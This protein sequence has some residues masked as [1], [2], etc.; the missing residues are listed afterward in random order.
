MSFSNLKVANRLYLGFGLLLALLLGIAVFSYTRL[1]ALNDNV[2]LLVNDRYAKILLIDSISSNV[3]LIARAVRNVALSNDEKIN[4]QELDRI[5]KAREENEQTLKKLREVII[6]GKGKDLLVELQ[7]SGVEYYGEQQNLLTTLQKGDVNEA[8]ALLFGAMR[9]KQVAMFNALRQLSDYQRAA[10]DQ[11]VAQSH[12]TYQHSSVLLSA[13]SAAAFILSLIAALLITRSILLQLGGE[14]QYAMAVASDIANGDL[15][16]SIDLRSGDQT[17][18]MAS[19]RLM[20]NR[21]AEIVGHVRHGTDTIATASTQIATGNLDLSSRT[22]EQASSLEETASAMEQL[23]STVKQNADNARQANQLAASASEVAMAG[24]DVVGKVVDTMGSINASS[25]KIVDIISVIDG[26]AFQT[27]ILALNA[28]VEAARAGEQGRGFAVVASEVRSL[29]QR[30]ASAAKEIKTLIDDSV[31]QVAQGS[32]LVEQAGATM[33]D[34]VDS[35]RRVTDVVGEIS[36]ASQEQSEGIEQVNL[37]ITQMDEVT[38]QNAALVEEAAAAAQSLQDQ[39]G[40]LSEVV[41]IFKLGNHGL[42]APV[43]RAPAKSPATDITPKVARIQ[44]ASSIKPAAER[45]LVARPAGAT[46][47]SNADGWEQF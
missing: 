19:I 42:A 13:V 12:E 18:L 30:S 17:S 8:R 15:S 21:L 24:G 47:D 20:R 38:Q 39:A 31:A 45:K 7:R 41:S 35:V 40:R 5:K 9:S 6:S 25:K 16:T 27:N 36:S 29:A 22:E 28:A 43:V 23:T 26:I 4:A 2:N 3:N 34:V 37:A 44:P 14:P 1:A 10:M 11:T 33:S 46:A 32:M